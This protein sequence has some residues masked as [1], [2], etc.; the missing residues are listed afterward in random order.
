MGVGGGGEKREREREREREMDVQSSYFF[1][2]RV[3][4]GG[5]ERIA[6]CYDCPPESSFGSNDTLMFIPASSAAKY[7]N[8]NG[9]LTFFT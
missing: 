1:H 7:F 2:V 8:T 5:T 4:G 9:T 3:C 6:P